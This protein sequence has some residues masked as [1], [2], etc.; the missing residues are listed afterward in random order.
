MMRLR[1]LVVPCLFLL[2]A[3]ST[4]TPEE[5]LL[6]SDMQHTL[7]RYRRA[8]NSK[9]FVV[10][11]DPVHGW[12][13]NLATGQLT[14]KDARSAME[15]CE[16]TRQ[17]LGVERPC[18]VYLRGDRRVAPLPE[19]PEPRLPPELQAALDAY[20]E[21]SDHRAF[22]MAVDP[23]GGSTWG[24]S[25]SYP[26]PEEAATAALDNCE[27]ARQESGIRSACQL[28]LRGDEFVGAGTPAA[29]EPE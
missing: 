14:S 4:A 24:Y 18:T 2:T 11:V 20:G 26:T 9:L 12:I 27:K 6:P 29:A 17:A 21:L 16:H 22:A 15:V 8:P 10:T 5:A 13:W 25:H 3:C 28:W 23:G 19:T 7:K 1:A